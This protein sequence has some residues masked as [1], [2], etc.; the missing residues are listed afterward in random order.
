MLY[1][2]M[3]EE[4]TVFQSSKVSYTGIFSFKDFYAFCYNWLRDETQISEFSEDK[5]SEKLAGD[6]KN[7]DIEWTGTRNLTDYFRFKIKVTFTIKNLV[8]VKVKKEGVE[9][10]TNK[11][12]VDLKVKGI[13]V[14][15]Y[16][17]KFEMT[18]FK[19]TLRGFYEKYIIQPAV[20]EFKGKIAADCDEF[21][22]QAK[23]FLDLEGRRG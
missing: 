22:T 15:D 8:Q 4:E 10:D 23:S 16:Q 11:G 2:K 5:Y 19:K 7:I 13:I 12:I 1:K 9:M 21:M 14:K 3:A 20:K 6:A 17:N 18:A